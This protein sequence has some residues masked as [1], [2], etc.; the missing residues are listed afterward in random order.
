MIRPARLDRDRDALLAVQRAGYAVEAELIGVELLPPQH[1]TID[2]LRA[3]SVWVAEDDHGEITG[4]LGVEHGP[5]LV[6]SRL[7]VRPDRMQRG[8][9]RALAEHAL[10][11]AGGSPVRVGTAAANIPALTLYRALGF[12]PVV[13]KTVGDGIPYVELRHPGEA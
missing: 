2:D 6:I 13:H 8:I 1:H 3:E 10:A 12:E 4:I 5:E 11:L 9:G 7:V